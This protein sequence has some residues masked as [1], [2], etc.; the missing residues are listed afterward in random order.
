MREIPPVSSSTISSQSQPQNLAALAAIALLL[1]E[2]AISAP[3][4][5]KMP[6]AA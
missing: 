2:L 5:G 4:S 6:M 1:A 3:T